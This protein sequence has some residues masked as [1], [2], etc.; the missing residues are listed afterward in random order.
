MSRYQ[1]VRK[2]ADVS[3]DFPSNGIPTPDVV[4][5]LIST[6]AAVTA[7]LFVTMDSW[8]EITDNTATWVSYKT[9]Q[10]ESS[11]FEIIEYGPT[12]IKV[13]ASGAGASCWVKS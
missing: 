13:T 5:I 12:G 11:L 7:E 10:A 8:E 9:V 4:T 2:Y 1:P 6:P 3:T